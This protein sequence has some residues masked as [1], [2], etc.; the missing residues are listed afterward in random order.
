MKKEVTAHFKELLTQRMKQI[1][2]DIKEVRQTIKEGA[3]SGPMDDVDLTER[4]Y[5][6]EVMM[7][8]QSRNHQQLQEIV[9]ALRRLE[10]GDFGICT[11]CEEP[12]ALPRLQA[13]PTTM[14][15]IHCKRELEA[16]DRIKVA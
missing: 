6:L 2:P 4:R 10:R 8:L 14:V 13:Q 5:A 7:Q 1:L 16:L 15:C 11:L 12:I 3:A 9:A